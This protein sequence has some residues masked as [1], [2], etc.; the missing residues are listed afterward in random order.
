MNAVI[1]A[2]VLAMIAAAII[3]LVLIHNHNSL[4]V[5]AAKVDALAIKVDPVIRAGE[6]D[7][8]PVVTKSIA[9]VDAE[10]SAAVAAKP[11]DAPVAPAAAPIQQ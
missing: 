5:A 1:V 2:L 8:I 11:A 7:L 9:E 10:V 4:D 3:A 6:A